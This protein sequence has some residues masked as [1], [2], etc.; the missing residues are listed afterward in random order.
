MSGSGR[1]RWPTPPSR[2]TP[3]GRSCSGRRAPSTA[4]S[5]R[6]R[7]T[8]STRCAPSVWNDEDFRERIA[9]SY[10]GYL[11]QFEASAPGSK[12]YFTPQPLFLTVTT[13]WAA[14]LQ[15]MVAKEVPVDEG[16]D[17]LAA[18]VD[19]QLKQAGLG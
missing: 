3:P 15:Q 1:W 11:E 4:C 5:A 17:Q 9:K 8:S 16:L 19:E 2:R 12:I 14:T 7:W 10:P 18:S 13:E 6:A